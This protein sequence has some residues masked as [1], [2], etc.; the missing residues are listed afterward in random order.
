MFDVSVEEGP[1]CSCDHVRRGR[2]D[3]RWSS[4]HRRGLIGP[5]TVLR[6]IRL[7]DP[8]R[9]L[10]HSGYAPL[11]VVQWSLYRVNWPQL[12]KQN[13]PAPVC[14]SK[15]RATLSML[16]ATKKLPSGDHARSYISLP[17]GD[18]HIRLTCHD[19]LS[20]CESSPYD[21]ETC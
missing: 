13:T 8:M 15:M 5:R 2:I 12:E 11:S 10:A 17:E 7:E 21:F 16:P 14:A 20:S 3:R 19:S 4:V 9:L 1:F 6:G 18:R